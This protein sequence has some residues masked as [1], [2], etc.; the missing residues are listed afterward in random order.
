M[1]QDVIAG[2]VVPN[3]LLF[4]EPLD[5]VEQKTATYTDGTSSIKVTAIIQATSEGCEFSFIDP[6]SLLSQQWN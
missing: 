5:K 1:G 4:T 3:K 2:H 6:P